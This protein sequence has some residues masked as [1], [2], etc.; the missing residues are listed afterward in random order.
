MPILSAVGSSLLSVGAFGLTTAVNYALSDLINWGIAL[1]FIVGGIAGGLLGL[2][3]ATRL[4]IRRRALTY[5][6]VSINCAVAVYLLVRTSKATYTP[7]P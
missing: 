2:R 3:A 4:A 7:L 6:Y 1:L 5:T